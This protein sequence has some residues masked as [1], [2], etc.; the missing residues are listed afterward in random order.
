MKKYLTTIPRELNSSNINKAIDD[1][2]KLLNEL[3]YSVE[4]N[5]AFVFLTKIKREKLNLGPYPNVALFEAANRIMTDLV[6]LYGVKEL[7]SG[8]I[9]NVKFE[10]YT[11][12]FGNENNNSNDIIAYSQ[13][14]KLI[15]EAF[16]VSKSFFQAKKT[17]A[18]KKMRKQK[19][20]KS[21]ILLVYNSD[22]TEISYRPKLKKNEFHLKVALKF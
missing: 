16:N 2:K 22:A 11:V 8:K 17:S 14:K 6:I 9:P 20:S 21:I 15:G 4:S 7:L 18:L 3:P 10:K 1:Y 19:T 5:N 13:N 12:E